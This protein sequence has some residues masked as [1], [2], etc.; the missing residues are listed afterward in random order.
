MNA[1]GWARA[2]AAPVCLRATASM[3]LRHSASGS[4]LNSSRCRAP[5]PPRRRLDRGN[6]GGDLIV[7]PGLAQHALGDVGTDLALDLDRQLLFQHLTGRDQLAVAMLGHLGVEPFDQ[8][9]RRHRVQFDAVGLEPVHPVAV[10]IVD[11]V[12]DRLVRSFSSK[13]SISAHLNGLPWF[14]AARWREIFAVQNLPV[15]NR[16]DMRTR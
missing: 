7:K 13:V 4:R 12:G 11:V 1:K 6:G 15:G 3:W 9:R 2:H 10:M 16:G 14:E 8:L 5:A